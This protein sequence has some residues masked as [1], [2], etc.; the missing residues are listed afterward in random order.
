MASHHG[1]AVE[2]S[3]S[4]TAPPRSFRQTVHFY[5]IDYRT[6]IGRGIDVFI[7]ALNLL[8][9]G[10]FVANTYPISD[11]FRSLLWQAELVAV[12]FFILEFSARL[13]GTYDRRGH[14]RNVYTIIDLVA[15]F[16]TLLELVLPAFGL[17][18]SVGFIKTIRVFAV[19]RIFRFLRFFA[20]DH[21]FF[22]I[23]AADLL[24]VARLTL[25]ILIIFFVSSGL[26]YYV[27]SPYNPDV[28]DFGAAFYFT[29]VALST[30]G[31]GDITPVSAAGRLVTVLMI[32]SGIILIPWQASQIVKEWLNIYGRKKVVCSN[33]GLSHH[34]LDASHCRHCGQVLFIREDL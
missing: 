13:Y 16:P 3:N 6:A 2:K 22:G 32:I 20:S 5:M 9:C 24:R 19:F 27:E 34:E 4:T 28:Q 10:I 8:V 15:I 14:M 7:I 33:C 21:L 29:V 26:F 17:A 1:S 12:F 23:I 31:F 25:T 11:D 30:V 18:V